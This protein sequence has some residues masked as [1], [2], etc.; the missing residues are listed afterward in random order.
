MKFSLTVFKADHVIS[1]QYILFQSGGLDNTNLHVRV[2]SLSLRDL[3]SEILLGG[4]YAVSKERLV[5][6]LLWNGI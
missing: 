2:C 5:Q 3:G 6:G 1:W 4:V